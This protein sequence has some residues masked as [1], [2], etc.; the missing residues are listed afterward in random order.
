MR[1]VQKIIG[2]LEDQL[3]SAFSNAQFEGTLLPHMM[4]IAVLAPA[5]S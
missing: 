1:E 5:R 3:E 4:A 2:D